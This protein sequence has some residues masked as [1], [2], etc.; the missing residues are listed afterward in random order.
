[1]NGLSDVRL[2]LRSQE[3]QVFDAQGR[4]LRTAPD[5]LGFWGLMWHRLTTRRALLDLDA[6]QL[7][8]IGLSP[9][10]AREEGAKPFWRE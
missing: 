10:E 8:D 7:R 5:G 9:G 4:R 3:L 1:M 6:D 2:L